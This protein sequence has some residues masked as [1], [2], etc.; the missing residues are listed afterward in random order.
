M[1]A[2]VAH[3]GVHSIDRRD[4]DGKV[5]MHRS[6]AVSSRIHLKI[7]ALPAEASLS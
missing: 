1:L 6:K 5:D 4:I 7:M 2:Q 3:A